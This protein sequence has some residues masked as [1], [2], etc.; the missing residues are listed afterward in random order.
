MSTWI[1]RYNGHS[2]LGR[3]NTPDYRGYVVRVDSAPNREK[4]FT[5]AFDHEDQHTYWIGMTYSE[6]EAKALLERLVSE[7]WLCE[8][9]ESQAGHHCKDQ[10][11]KVKLAWSES[12]RDIVRTLLCERHGHVFPD[13]EELTVRE[14]IRTYN[15]LVQDAQIIGSRL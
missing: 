7:G 3:E 1:E 8:V 9:Y 15:G 2:K 4:W 12:E 13:W 14:Y 10:A 11:V 6:A 5:Y